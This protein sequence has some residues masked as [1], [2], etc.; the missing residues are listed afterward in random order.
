MVFY[1]VTFC[2]FFSEGNADQSPKVTATEV[3]TVGERRPGAGVAQPKPE[4]AQ[5][6]D[7]GEWLTH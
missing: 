6:A 5:R 7:R 3:S 4:R 1:L 2:R